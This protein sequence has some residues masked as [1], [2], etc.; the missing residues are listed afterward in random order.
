MSSR[1]QISCLP[2]VSIP[3]HND[4]THMKIKTY[5][6]IVCSSNY[7]NMRSQTQS[8]NS[9]VLNDFFFYFYNLLI[10]KIQSG[11]IYLRKFCP[12]INLIMKKLLYVSTHTER[13]R[14]CLHSC[15]YIKC[16]SVFH[17]CMS[18]EKWIVSSRK[19]LYFCWIKLNV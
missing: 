18:V 7:I 16:A 1:W 17:V 8:V 11:S 14:T 5:E 2:R 10:Y 12:H 6:I 3:R 15:A 9:L 4:I 19:R 13:Y